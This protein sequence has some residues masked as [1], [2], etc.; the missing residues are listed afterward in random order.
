MIDIPWSLTI[1]LEKADDKY[2]SMYFQCRRNQNQRLMSLRVLQDRSITDSTKALIALIDDTDKQDEFW[3][4][5]EETTDNLIA[6][7]RKKNNIPDGDILGDDT[8]RRIE[9]AASR[10]TSA[11]VGEWFGQFWSISQ[12][13][14]IMFERRDTDV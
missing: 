12:S 1:P 3:K 9:N 8:L 7:Y 6:E 10:Q 5:H 14:E 4:F 11:K 13:L 2:I